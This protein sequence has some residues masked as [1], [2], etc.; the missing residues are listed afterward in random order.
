MR[1]HESS[2]PFGP[3]PFH[4]EL[5]YPLPV[6]GTMASEVVMSQTEVKQS[7]WRPERDCP[8]SIVVYSA[9]PRIARRS[10]GS[11]FAQD[12]LVATAY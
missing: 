4:Q 10:R 3:L 6:Y 7:L 12:V 11:R 2:G 1:T 5:R 8:D 9:K